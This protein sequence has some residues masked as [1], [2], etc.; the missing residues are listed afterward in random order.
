MLRLSK[1]YGK[2]HAASKVP[3][4]TLERI[5]TYHKE[6]FDG[7]LEEGPIGDF[8]KEP[9]GVKDKTT[10]Q[11]VFFATPP[12]ETAAEL[13]VLL[14]WF[15]GPAQALPPAV[16]AGLF[17]VEFE[18]IHPFT[19]GNG[20][21]GRFLNLVA[22]KQ[23]GFE[24]ACLVPIDGRFFRSGPRYYESL[25]AT[26]TGT[27]YHVWLRYYAKELRK[28]YEI[29]SKRADLRTLLDQHTKRSTRS[30]LEWVVSGDGSWFVH[31][32][33]PNGENY[34][35]TAVSIGLADLLKE[36]VLEHRG[37]RRGRRYRLHP[38]FLRKLYNADF[39]ASEESGG[40]AT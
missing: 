13:Q 22:L 6:F 23:V 20:R 7:L 28:A 4:L 37:E 18:A 35:A 3:P 29:A 1:A 38:D 21:L 36:G 31:S 11:W 14:D 19:D 26:N 9:N 17:F 10:G 16:A 8:K 15:Y 12:E 33:Y 30:I 27:N 39:L 24:N 32:D 34:S 2:L 40:A 5:K 25:A